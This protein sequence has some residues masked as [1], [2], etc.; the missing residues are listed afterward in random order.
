MICSSIGG[1]IFYVAN[2]GADPNDKIDDTFPIP[3][4]I[5][6]AMSHGANN[7]VILGL[8]TYYFVSPI[9][10][11][12]ATNLT[13]QEQEMDQTLLIGTAS[14]SIFLGKSCQGLTIRLLSIDYYPRPFTAGYIVRV[15]NSYLD[16]EIES[17]HEPDIDRR[18]HSIFRYDPIAM[19]PAFGPNA[20]QFFQ[21]TL[22]NVS[23]SLIS[24]GILRVPLKYPTQ[25][26]V[27]DPIVV[28]YLS[29][30]HAIEL[31][32]MSPIS[33]FNQ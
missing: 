31:K 23:T 18:V 6:T 10:I 14:I 7:I 27:G 15:N 17:P 9:E 26:T 3:I 32:Y 25:F 11:L 12:N 1:E 20:Y 33:P 29:G 22:A 30:N 24:P 28:I 16:V 4:T 8:G 5:D 2:F 21:E 19:R 13:I